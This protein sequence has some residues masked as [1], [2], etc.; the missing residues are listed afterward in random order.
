MLHQ[1]LHLSHMDSAAVS[2]EAR[3]RWLRSTAQLDTHT[4]DLMRAV[5]AHTRRGHTEHETAVSIHDFV[6]AIPFAWGGDSLNFTASDALKLGYADCFTKGILMV[7]LLRAAKLPARLRFV[8]LNSHIWRGIVNLDQE[9]M[10]H[11]ITEV[12]LG[13]RWIFTDSYVMDE[14]LQR[15]AQAN[16]DANKKNL[17]YGIHR[18]GAMNWDGYGD[19]SAQCVA[20]DVK[21]LPIHDWGVAADPCSFFEDAAHAGLRRD[22][23]ERLK[24]RLFVPVVNRRVENLRSQAPAANGDTQPMW[25]S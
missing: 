24:W 22:L 7:A 17:G 19:A 18:Y 10:L 1:S 3:L 16:L 15:A 14:P 2:N 5:C 9:T 21:S 12:M 23:A 6:K 4:P 20:V 11:A 13:N 25:L 8:S